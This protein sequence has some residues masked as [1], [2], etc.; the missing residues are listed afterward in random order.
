MFSE[1]R[2][3]VENEQLSGR[4]STTR[5]SDNTARIREIV[6]S[7]GRLAVKLIA[8]EVNAHSGAVRRIPNGELEM[9]IICAMMVFRNLTEQQRDAR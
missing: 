7:D 1:G 5:T 8:D 2:T 9:R 3:I 6:R 4:T